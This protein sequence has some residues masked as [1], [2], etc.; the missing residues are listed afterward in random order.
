LPRSSAG[1]AGLK[2]IDAP[3]GAQLFGCPSHLIGIRTAALLAKGGRGDHL[4]EDPDNFST[5]VER[6]GKG[7]LCLA[8]PKSRVS[9][10]GARGHSSAAPAFEAPLENARGRGR[11]QRS[12]LGEKKRPG[13]VPIDF[14]I[15]PAPS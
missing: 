12:Q 3:A 2:A 10:G 9:D 7:V 5:F 8:A 4:G 11:D 1:D 14:R 13:G 15:G 6:A